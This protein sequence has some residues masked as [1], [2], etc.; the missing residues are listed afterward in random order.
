MLR[1]I[2]AVD[3]LNYPEN[4]RALHV[5][6]APMV[7]ASAWRMIR[8]FLPPETA[9]KVHIFGERASDYLPALLE[10]VDACLLPRELGG[11]SDASVTDGAARHASHVFMDA[12]IARERAR[13][14]SFFRDADDAAHAAAHP[15]HAS[16]ALSAL[17]PRHGPPPLC[18]VGSTDGDEDGPIPPEMYARDPGAD[19][20]EPGAAAAV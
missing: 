4:L 9:A 13:R 8:K 2:A 12:H 16:R 10:D 7:F 3:A 5:L 15:A 17:T 19:V 20:D 1:R 6:N 14:A 11:E 18:T